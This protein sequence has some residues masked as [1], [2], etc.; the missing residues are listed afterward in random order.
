MVVLTLA[1]I[2]E[3]HASVCHGPHHESQCQTLA[4]QCGGSQ[5]QDQGIQ[6]RWQSLTWNRATLASLNYIQ[7]L[8]VRAL[9]VCARRRSTAPEG[10]QKLLLADVPGVWKSL[11]TSG[12]GAG[13]GVEHRRG[14]IDGKTFNRGPGD[15][16]GSQGLQSAVSRK[17][18]TAKIK[19]R[20]VH[21]DCGEF[22][23][24]ER[25]REGVDATSISGT[26]AHDDVGRCT[27]RATA[28]GAEGAEP[29]SCLKDNEQWS[30]AFSGP[31]S[32]QEGHCVRSKARDARDPLLGE[33]QASNPGCGLRHADTMNQ[34]KQASL[35]VRK[36]RGTL[37]ITRSPLNSPKTMLLSTVLV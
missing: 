20:T 28:E 4:D 9:R 3:H 12:V 30:E 6:D 19:A 29:W 27:T 2:R 37:S 31:Q 32:L 36:A 24:A 13:C 21:F 25:R 22:R 33:R 16:G 11:G 5:G 10:R 8:A 34:T 23:L 17:T 1:M 18:A 35:H 26:H 14:I 15:A 7:N